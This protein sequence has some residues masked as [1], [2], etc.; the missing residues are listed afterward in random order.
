MFRKWKMSFTF[1]EDY[2]F[3]NVSEHN[4]LKNIALLSANT[5]FAVYILYPCSKCECFSTYYYYLLFLLHT[6]FYYLSKLTTS[7]TFGFAP[8]APLESP[9]FVISAANTKYKTC[10]FFVTIPKNK[11]ICCMGCIY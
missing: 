7:T 8:N 10:H 2:L 3:I 6:A 5:F 4:M 1:F 11:E 9:S